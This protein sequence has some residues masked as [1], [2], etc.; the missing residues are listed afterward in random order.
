ME[1]KGAGGTP[2]G[3]GHFFI[4]LAMLCVGMYLLLNSI[5]VT[6]TFFWGVGLFRFGGGPAITSGMVLIPFLFGVGIIFFNAKNPLGWIL[7]VGSVIALI[8]GVIA[9]I[10]FSFR[11]MSLFELLLIFILTFGGV[12]LLLRSFRNSSQTSG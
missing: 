11:H 3:I 8:A 12:G 10:H 7:A 6:N 1:F 2:G 4:G 9:N 5:V